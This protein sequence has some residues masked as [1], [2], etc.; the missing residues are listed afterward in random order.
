MYDNRKK[1]ER[2]RERTQFEII[3]KLLWGKPTF[4]FLKISKMLKYQTECCL[5]LFGMYTKLGK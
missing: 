2:E 4:I 5:K 1:R 3:R